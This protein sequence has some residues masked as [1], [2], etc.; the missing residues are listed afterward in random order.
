MTLSITHSSTEKKVRTVLK[1]LND[2]GIPLRKDDFL[3]SAIDEYIEK[4]TKSKVLH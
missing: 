2:K 3:I 1:K 4:L